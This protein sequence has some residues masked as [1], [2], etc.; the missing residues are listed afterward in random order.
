MDRRTFLQTSGSAALL[1]ALGLQPV[2][3]STGDAAEGILRELVQANDVA[4]SGLLARQER[5]PGHRWRGGIIDGNGLHTPRGTSE[6]VVALACA[7]GAADSVHYRSPKLAEPLRLAVNYLLAAQHDDG[8]IDLRETNFR[9]PPDTAFCL[10]SLC[11]ACV[12]LRAN[13]EPAFAPATAELG[14]FIVRAGEA[15]ITGGVHTPNHR[16]VVCAAL[17]SVHVLFPDPRLVTRID[18]W[19]AEGVDLDA[20]GQYTEKSTAIYSPVVDRAL[21]TVARLLNRPALREPVRRNLEM[22]L[23]YVHPDGEVVTEASRRQDRF[24]RGSMA[25]YYYSYRSLALLDGNGRFAAMARQIERTARGQF[26]GELSALLTEPELLAP[27]PADLPLP[28]DYARVFAGSNLARIRRGS[29]S[30]TILAT[31]TTLFSFRHGQAALEAVRLAS[32]FFG[33]GQFS[34]DT[35]KVEDG[36]Y[37]LRQTLEGPYFQP[38]SAEQIAAGEAVRMAPNGTLATD[39]R[40]LR[41]RSNI[42]TLETVVEITESA[43]RFQLAIT[44]EGTDE[45]PVAVELA[46]RHG[47]T[48]H[49]VKPVSGVDDAYLLESDTG[50]YVVG[51]DTITFGPGRVEHTYTQL[52]GAL[53]KWDG[54]SV[55]FT[56][57]TPFKTTLTIG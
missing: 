6:L 45:V 31:N 9:S 38:L 13:P 39:S 2:F 32:A 7:A 42:Q 50:R 15:L 21:L 37:V 10:E 44:I 53:P 46:F 55:Y 33:K 49:G 23:Y 29:A 27:L 16:W 22:T 30:G 1:G 3:G 11:P 47:G 57:V 51:E 43:G 12:L 40:A 4:I 34:A 35:L 18:A 36:R 25:R 19:L 24:Q 56:G 52:R 41:A 14:R 5:R 28:A 20:D 48:L 54:L 17:A 26:G 8:T